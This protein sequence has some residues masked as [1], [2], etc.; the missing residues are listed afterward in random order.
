MTRLRTTRACDRFKCDPNIAGWATLTR[1]GGGRQRRRSFFSVLALAL[2]GQICS[3]GQQS[4]APQN[5]RDT[6]ETHVLWVIPNFRTMS[7]PQPYRPASVKEKFQIAKQDSFDR[8]AVALAAVFAADG[9][10]T[11]SNKSFGHGAVGYTHYLATAYSD[12]A[13]GNVMTEAIFPTFLHEDP[14]FFRRGTGSSWSRLKYAVG[15]IFITYTDSGG[16]QFNFSEFGGN[17]AAVAISMAYYPENRSA[18]NAVS[19]VGLQ[20]ALDAASNV[21]KEFWPQDRRR[22][23]SPS[24]GKGTSTAK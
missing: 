6:P 17:S 14:R 7:L 8:G 18:S 3:P 5:V 12:V 20:I 21:L 19:K 13:L 23:A 4:D 2:L 11:D 24:G 15:Q 16:K 1:P 10:A 9:L 22:R